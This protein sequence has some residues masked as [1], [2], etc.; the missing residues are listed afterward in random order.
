M[1]TGF[2]VTTVSSVYEAEAYLSTNEPLQSPLDFVI[3]DDQSETLADDLVHFIQ[4]LRSTALQ[5]TKII[6][7]YT[8]TTDSLSGHPLVSSTTPGVL[9]MTK[10]PRTARLLQTLARLKDLPSVTSLTSTS[11]ATK[12]VDDPAVL[13]RTLYGNVLIAEG[14]VCCLYGRSSILNAQLDNPVAQKLLARQLQQYQ[15]NVTA[16]GN[17]I[18]ALAGQSA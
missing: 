4:S 15:L 17:G 10:P 12:I 14:A 13:Q 16:T 9:K 3:L 18:E 1:L 2:V 5:E 8:P 11:N 7:L 6:H